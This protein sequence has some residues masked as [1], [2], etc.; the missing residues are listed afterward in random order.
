MSSLGPVLAALVAISLVS[1]AQAASRGTEPARY[2][3]AGLAAGKQF[4]RFIVKYH[5]GSLEA[6]DAGALQLSL[7]RAATRAVPWR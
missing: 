4:D 3:L 7:D 1:P 5:A 2:S 6:T